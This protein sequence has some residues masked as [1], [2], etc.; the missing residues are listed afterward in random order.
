MSRRKPRRRPRVAGFT[1][2]ELLVATVLL[3]AA[4]TLG[5]ATLRAATR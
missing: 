3:A 4:M 2:I 1:L 5:F